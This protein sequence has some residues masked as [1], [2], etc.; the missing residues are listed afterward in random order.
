MNFLHRNY[1]NIFKKRVTLIEDF[2]K[3]CIQENTISSTLQ[4]AMN[5]SLLAGGKRLRA[6]LCISSAALFDL[7]PTSILPFA[8]G[9]EMI[10]TYSLIH[11]DLPAMDDDDFRRGKPSC[12]KAFNEALA[13]LAGDALLT[14]AFTFMSTLNSIIPSKNI[15]IAIH[16]IAQAAGSNGMVKGQSMDIEYTGVSD[17][18]FNTLCI[19]HE[20]KTGALF[21]A[22]CTTGAMLAGANESAIYALKCYGE[23]LGAA[24]QITDDILN[25]TADSITLGKPTGSDQT[26]GKITYPSL[27][28]LEKSKKLAEEK[29]HLAISSLDIFTGDEVL[30]LKEVANSLLTRT[31]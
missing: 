5:Y 4:H 28:G 13:I 3:T 23:A 8:A 12:H 6:V 1:Q 25:V 24:F 29:I 31:H 20:H 2:L 16:E 21:R 30:F 27:L 19:I 22:S 26:K 7:S 14:D 15:L 17:V 11:D 18:S 9:I 10:H